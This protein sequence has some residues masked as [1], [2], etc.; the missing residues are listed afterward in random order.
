[1]S[2]VIGKLVLGLDVGSVAVK[3]LILD[4]QGQMCGRAVVPLTSDAR[5]AV[6]QVLRS[7]LPKPASPVLVGVT[8]G[9][10]GL[11]G[12]LSGVV[13]ENDLV[14]TARAVG[15]RLPHVRGSI[16]IGGHQSKWISNFGCGP[17]A[18]S[19]K[20][21]ERAAGSRP[22]LYLEFDEHRGE[23]GLVTRLEAFADEVSPTPA[24]PAQR[25]GAVPPPAPPRGQAVPG[26]QDHP[27]L[28]LGSRVGV[29]RSAALRRN[30]RPSPASPG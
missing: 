12:E 21:L 1:M 13:C 4:A 20:F 17:D 18:F 23:A 3:G 24:N 29:S 15:Q 26:M 11:L 7:L 10:K 22:Y 30:G 2:N 5:A 9:G 8:G 25:A 14:A 6:L 19:M 16:E 28:V 27:A